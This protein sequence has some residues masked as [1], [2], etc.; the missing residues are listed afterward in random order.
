MMLTADDILN[1]NDFDIKKINIP[2][3]GGDVYIKTMSG[4]ARDTWEL[5]AQSEIEKTSNVNMR[6]KMCVLTLCDEKGKLLFDDKQVSNLGQKSAKALDRVYS[7][8]VELN[9]IT[10][11]EIEVI[12]KNLIADQSENFG[13]A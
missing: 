8:A 11:E 9:K 5:Y 10:A 13:S 3:W 6:A 1:S 4:S 7:K 12:E 2:E